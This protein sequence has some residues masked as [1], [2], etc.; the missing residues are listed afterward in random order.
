MIKNEAQKNVTPALQLPG[1]DELLCAKELADRLGHHP[2]YIYSM[3]RDGFSMP[4]GVSTV[5]AALEHL[6]KHPAP[7][8]RKRTAKDQ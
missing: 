6:R 3:K 2:K 8:R 4:G 1:G 7:R 5:H